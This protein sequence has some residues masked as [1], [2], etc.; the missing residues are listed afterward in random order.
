MASVGLGFREH[1]HGSMVGF[2]FR[3]NGS[4]VSLGFREHDHGSMV[5][6]G[7]RDNGSMVGATSN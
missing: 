7:F 3:D 2:G 1:D 4:V 5:G 6:L